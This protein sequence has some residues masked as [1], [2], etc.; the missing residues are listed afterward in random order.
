MILTM[1]N[2]TGMRLVYSPIHNYV[3]NYDNHLTIS[4][5]D[6]QLCSWKITLWEA[7]AW[8]CSKESSAKL[9]FP[10]S[11]KFLWPSHLHCTETLHFLRV[12]QGIW[13]LL[14]QIFSNADKAHVAKTLSKLGLEDCF[15]RIICF[16]TLNPTTSDHKTGSEMLEIFESDNGQMLPKTPIVCK[17]FEDAFEQA[18]KLADINPQ[19]T[20]SSSFSRL[21]LSLR[22][23]I[24]FICCFV[25]S[26]I[27]WW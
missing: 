12:R 23:R 4:N 21:Q 22:L 25:F 19:R 3:K 13:F 17:P 6:L 8:P 5:Y 10:Q 15:E 26:D 1:M 20:V 27:L 11:C 9:A 18:F 2:I 24:L 7:E 16:E 14:W